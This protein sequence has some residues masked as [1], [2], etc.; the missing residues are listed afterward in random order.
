MNMDEKEVRSKRQSEV[1]FG[2]SE[3]ERRIMQIL[4]EDDKIRNECIIGHGP[5]QTVRSKTFTLRDFETGTQ[6]RRVKRFICIW[7]LI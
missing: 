4:V 3:T 6:E 7:M 5:S 1:S 2:G